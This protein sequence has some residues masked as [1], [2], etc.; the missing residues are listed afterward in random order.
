MGSPAHPV[1]A[2]GDAVGVAADEATTYPERP[3]SA[4][5]Y[6]GSPKLSFGMST[7]IPLASDTNSLLEGVRGG[8]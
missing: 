6:S 3:A 5:A 2:C 7:S 8:A 1:S 4:P